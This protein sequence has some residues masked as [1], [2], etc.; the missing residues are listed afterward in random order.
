MM[1]HVQSHEKIGV[2]L[3][4][5]LKPGTERAEFPLPEGVARLEFP[6]AL[7]AASYEDMQAWLELVLRR[8]KRSVKD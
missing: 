1:P 5:P 7:S 6:A 4:T 8:A 2:M 3:P